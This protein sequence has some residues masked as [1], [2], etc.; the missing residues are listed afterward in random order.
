MFQALFFQAFRDA[1]ECEGSR[2]S[3]DGIAIASQQ[4]TYFRSALHLYLMIRIAATSV[5]RAATEM[6]VNSMRHSAVDCELFSGIG[7]MVPFSVRQDQTI[8][9]VG[10]GSICRNL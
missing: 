10:L 5:V 8:R 2:K 7:N 9:F 4:S 6:F 1:K 3:I